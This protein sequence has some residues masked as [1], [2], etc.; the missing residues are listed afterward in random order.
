[1]AALRYTRHAR[2]QMRARRI[3]A[4]EVEAV[5]LDPDV[6]HGGKQTPGRPPTEIRRRRVR[7]RSLKVV[8]ALTD[9]ET[10]ITAASPQE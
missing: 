3:T 4:E 9:P 2:E 5:V 7:G 6:V 8:V 1:M 10:V